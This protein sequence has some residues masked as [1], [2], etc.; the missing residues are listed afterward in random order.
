VTSSAKHL[1]ADKV[2]DKI[3][4]CGVTHIVWLADGVASFMY[5]SMMAQKD[6]TLVPVCREGEALPIAA[7]LVLG[8]KKPLVLHQSTGIFESGDSIRLV[9]SELHLPV[10]MLIG[11]RSWKPNPPVTDSAA[12]F[13]EPI[14][15]AWGIKY[16]LLRSD[17]DIDVIST[18]DIEAQKTRKPVVVL[19]ARELKL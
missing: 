11:Y 15:K 18:A 3:K 9:A 7:G 6:L 2:I 12:I 1:T 5:Q 10:L 8:G 13:I 19:I 14:L 17:H 16:Y 4:E